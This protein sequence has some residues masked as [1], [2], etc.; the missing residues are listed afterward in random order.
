MEISHFL[1]ELEKLNATK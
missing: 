1:F